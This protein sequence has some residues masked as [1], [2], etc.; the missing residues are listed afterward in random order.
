MRRVSSAAG[1]R[2]G[3]RMRVA[4]NAARKEMLD[5]REE[6]LKGEE[7]AAARRPPVPGWGVRGFGSWRR[8]SWLARTR[9]RSCAKVSAETAGR[10]GRDGG[11]LG[12]R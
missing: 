12:R 3:A 6:A 11:S 4:L 2:E 5:A 9:S 8:S 7:D 1:R 10:A